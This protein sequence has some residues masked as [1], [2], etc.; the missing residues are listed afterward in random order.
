MDAGVEFFT[1]GRVKR[2]FTLIEL[3]LALAIGMLV[4]IAATSMLFFVGQ[5]WQQSEELTQFEEHT[6]SVTQ[7]LEHIFAG[8]QVGG[9]GSL[10]KTVPGETTMED[11]VLSVRVSGELPLFALEDNSVIASA[12]VY[13]RV[14][15]GKGLV[16]DWQT[17]EQ[18]AEN[19]NKTNQTVIS[20]WVQSMEYAYYDLEND[21]WE[22][23]AEMI[24]ND[25]G[26]PQIPSFIKLSFVREDGREATSYVMLP[27][28]HSGVPS[29]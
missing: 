4:M 15:S 21:K 13:L 20:R 26:A 19:Q 16:I 14:V 2:A 22:H 8:N 27:S 5:L 23:A 1:Y 6:E 24:E 28:I 10:W 25:E 11:E 12:N 18:A 9:D 29:F 17:D 3:L 7:F